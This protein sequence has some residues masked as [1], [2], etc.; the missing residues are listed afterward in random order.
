MRATLCCLVIVLGA[1]VA[2]AQPGQAPYAQPPPAAGV[3]APYAYQPRQQVV[4][5]E[6]ER[7]LLEQGEITDGRHVGGG[8]AAFVFGFGVGQ[9]VQGRWTDT[10]YIFTLGEG[11]SMV[12]VVYGLGR[13][14]SCVDTDTSCN[15]DGGAWMLGGLLAYTALHVWEVVDAFVVPPRHNQRVRELRTRLGYPP[16]GVYYG[17]KPFVAPK[18]G[19]GAVAGFELRF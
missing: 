6:E 10:G 5:T 14:L 2:K 1:S 11:A 7:H 19:D 15:N 17:L 13:A 18:N 8:V 4:L 9:A 12:A 16:A 3:P